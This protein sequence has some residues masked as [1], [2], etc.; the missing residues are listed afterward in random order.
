MTIK[1]I[2]KVQAMLKGAV[3]LLANKGYSG[4]TIKEVTEASDISR[5]F[6]YYYFKDK[7]K[8]RLCSVKHF[9]FLGYDNEQTD[10]SSFVHALAYSSS[11]Y[12][13]SN[14]QSIRFCHWYT[15]LFSQ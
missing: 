2:Y 9:L 14:H 11:T 3:K 8:I 1:K 12:K 13:E 6:W 15:A 4:T 10:S 5:G 7:E